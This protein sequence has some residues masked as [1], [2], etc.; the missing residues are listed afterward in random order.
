MV[1]WIEC[2]GYVASVLVAV[3]LTLSNIRALRVVN[4]A[5]ALVFTVYGFL[6]SAYPVA[7]VNGFIVLVNIFYLV[8]SEKKSEEAFTLITTD[9]ED[10]LVRR[11]LGFYGSDIRT[12]F[13]EFSADESESL[14]CHV[15]LRDM[16][17]AGVF[18]HRQPGAGRIDVLVD[19][20]VPAYRDYR[21]A[22][23]LYGA[24]QVWLIGHG[25]DKMSTS[26]HVASH[27]RY[28]KKMG[29]RTDAKEPMRMSRTISAAG[30]LPAAH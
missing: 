27:R 29:F 26:S 30:N 5:G 17:P 3:S 22:T 19:Y 20:V 11:F 23:F 1:T 8:R 13:P 4:L 15:V 10:A 9:S 7:A 12:F 6:V 16:V 18:I 28:L 2:V 14:V 21:N 25:V 24:L